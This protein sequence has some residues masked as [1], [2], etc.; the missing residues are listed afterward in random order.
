MAFA[1]ILTQM[2]LAATLTGGWPSAFAQAV[3]GTSSPEADTAQS[4]Q[5]ATPAQRLS[6]A[7]SAYQ[8]RD[9]QKAQGLLASLVND[10][11]Y[12][13]PDLRQQ[14]RVYLGEVLYRSEDVEA[15]RRVF[16]RVLT[17]DPSYRIDPFRH[18]PDVCGF[19][20]TVRAY[21]QPPPPPKPVVT[22][23]LPPLPPMGYL[24][25]GLYQ[26]QSGRRGIG[27]TMLAGQAIAGIASVASF[28]HLIDNRIYP[29]GE[30]AAVS[31]TRNLQWASTT[32][33]WSIWAWSVLDA[34]R[35]WKA[36]ATPIPAGQTGTTPSAPRG[37][38][39]QVSGDFR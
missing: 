17:Q 30:L 4:E 38:R 36:T 18:P 19:F 35:H 28:S 8:A 24:G 12:Q 14:A 3:D 20:E 11:T 9:T 23:P 7:V 10:E 5:P 6:D 2:V 1:R 21:I 34:G 15:A 29:E 33:F 32:A 37:I 39:L 13:D 27:A 26:L 22:G 16:E 31:S 25:F